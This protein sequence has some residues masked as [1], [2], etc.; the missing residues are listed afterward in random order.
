MVAVGATCADTDERAEYLAKP[1][2]LSFLRLR[3]G[4]PIR[5]P[6]PEEAAEYEF[7]PVEQAFVEQRKAGQALGSPSTVAAQLSEL[8]G[9]TGAD[10]L[11]LTNQIYELDDRLR[12]YQLIAELSQRPTPDPAGALRVGS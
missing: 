9:R 10:E 1:G 2:W 11:M 8:L 12:S 7:S 3:S 4:A 5:L 6:S